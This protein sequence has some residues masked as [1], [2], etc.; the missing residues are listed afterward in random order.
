MANANTILFH[1]YQIQRHAIVAIV[2]AASARQGAKFH[3]SGV[4]IFSKKKNKDVFYSNMGRLGIV[5]PKSSSQPH[6]RREAISHNNVGVGSQ[7]SR[8]V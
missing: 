6:G 8:S 1:I 4:G 7:Q 5:D 2:V 3:L